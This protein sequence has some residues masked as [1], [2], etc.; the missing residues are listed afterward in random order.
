[1]AII[2]VYPQTMNA[3]PIGQAMLKNLTIQMGNCNHRKYVPILV[4]L[5]RSGVVDPMQ[6]LSN[7]EPL[8][9]V[10]EAYK[11]FD[12]REPGWIKVEIVPKREPAMA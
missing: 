4:E 5:V 12:R 11:A 2:G 9:S 3:F 7:V 10:I 6:V 1:M 8:T